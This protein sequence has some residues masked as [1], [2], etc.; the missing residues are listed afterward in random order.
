M[1]KQIRILAVFGLIAMLYCCS[2]CSTQSSNNG[3]D[4]KEI[5]PWNVSIFLDLSDRIIKQENGMKQDEKDTIIVNKVIDV[6]V[7][8]VVKDKIT[9]S[10][11]RIKVFFYPSPQD[12][13]INNLSRQM[14]VDF[15]KIKSADKRKKLKDLKSDFS[16]CLS[17]IY[18]Q[19]MDEKN[20][21]G[22]DIWGFFD[23]GK[24]S[25]FCIKE[26]YRNILIIL[27]DGYIFHANNKI[28]QGS[29]Y[30]YILPQTISAGGE[31]IP[32]DSLRGDLEILFLEINANPSTDYKAIKT[33]LSKWFDNM[34]IK[35]YE[36]KD[37]DIPQNTNIVVENFLNE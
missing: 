30:S 21:V 9:K 5:V 22:S 15:S 2:G 17:Q 14:E 8:K 7:C 24:V 18:T 12:K 27:S 33:C 23:K 31:L 37:T 6:F 19:T 28:K 36:I 11:D 1:N 29:Q 20:W 25:D 35:K 4:K 34:N 3:N 32:C 26:G 13:S 16:N 10:N